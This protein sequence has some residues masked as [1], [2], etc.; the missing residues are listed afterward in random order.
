MDTDAR[1]TG[2]SIKN[3]SFGE[4]ALALANDYESIYVIDSENDS[5]VEYIAE[6]DNKELV[7]R[8]SG[9]DFYADVQV[10]CPAMVH[11]EDQA[12]FLSVFKKENVTEVLGSGRSFSI[13][14]R[15]IIDGRPYYYFLKTIKGTGDK[16]FIGVQ[17]VD[18]QRRH[19]LEM[20]KENLTYQ[21]IAGS[22]ASRYEVI[23]Y[24]NVWTNEFIMYS[25]SD[26]YSKL[27]RAIEG[28]DFFQTASQDIKEF[29]YHEDI[30]YVLAEL[31][32]DNLMRHLDDSG[33][34]SLKYRQIGTSEPQYMN[35]IIVHPKDDESHIVIGVMNIDA[36]ERRE[37]SMLE[38]SE[39]FGAVS[40][41][42]ASRYEVIY[43]VN[44]HTNEYYEYSSC[45]KYSKLEV[46]NI[47]K[48]FFKDTQENLKHEIYEEDYPMMAE[49][50]DKEKLL[51]KLKGAG[52]IFLNYRLML[53]GRPQYVSL[54]IISTKDDQDHIIVG[55]ENI[56]AA[57]RKE[58]EFEAAIGSA[59]DM[60]NKDALTG[61]K[62]KHAY[63]SMEAQLDSQMADEEEL[64]FAIA[65]CDINGL[66]QVNDEQGHSAGDKFIK[67]A[68]SII[69]KAFAHSP[70]FR[71]GGDEFVAVMRGSDYENRFEIVKK[72]AEI[73]N[74]NKREGLVTIAY[75]ISEYDPDRDNTVQDVFERADNLMY[76]NKRRIKGLDVSEVA[77][78]PYL[79]FYE[80]HEHLVTV[81][82]ESDH[83]DNEQIRDILAE[84]C[85]MFR[86]ARGEVMI[87]KNPQDEKNGVGDAI[88]CYDN[89]MMCRETIRLRF[90]TSLMS[91]AVC[92]VY[93][94][95]DEPPLTDEERGKVELIMRT[96]LS[97][98][99]SNI[100]NNIAEEL[101][102]Y[103]ESG[104]PNLRSWNKY[105]I[106]ALNTLEIRGKTSFRYNIRHFSIINQEF[107]RENGDA[108]M[109]THFENLRDIIGEGGF[110]ARLGGDNYIGMCPP[111]KL[112]EVVSYLDEA[113]VRVNDESE[114]QI[115]CK[116]GLFT[117]APDYSNRF[118]GD[119]MAKIISAYRAAQVSPSMRIVFYDDSI[120]ERKE[121]SMKVQQDFV[122]AIE[123]GEFVPFY[124][125]QVN[126]ITGEIIGAEAL[127]RWFRGGYMI[128]PMEFIPIL[129]QTDD[130]C[131]LDFHMLECVCRDMRRWM[132]EGR[133]MIAISVNFSRKHVLNSNLPRA[134]ADVLDRYGVPHEFIEIELTETT[135][136][137][138]FNEIKRI[139]AGFHELGIR[140]SVDD[141]GVGYTSLNLIKDIKWDVLK[142]DR[143]FLPDENDEETGF[144]KIMYSSVVT[145]ASK[146]GLTVVSEGVETTGQMDVMRDVG[147][148]IAQGFYFD[149]PLPVET[150]EERL[151]EGRYEVPD[152]R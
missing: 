131:K 102:Y 40:T 76:E 15:L 106:H 141:F 6:G 89:G 66:K 30:H 2:S 48:D 1:V 33:T 23:Y 117:F 5:Y 44:I 151:K 103:D 36:Q 99:S 146:L 91:S 26:E 20:E 11:P 101:A 114:V 42:L 25:A 55:V 111:D 79:K 64:E 28:K 128:P 129:E 112:D 18:E 63:V 59:I 70:V 29:I 16:V 150:F 3:I 52:K 137:Y 145:M 68:C 14:Y 125:P 110:L 139:A 140:I 9:D 113:A 143:S 81:M 43:W 92:T 120:M 78:D 115:T 142:I 107:G 24:V 4:I 149:R 80:L 86:L 148:D 87:Y 56:D 94:T 84:L 7:V 54:V 71:I 105:M 57:K 82:T 38:E 119:L 47:G 32:K 90:V 50:M 85:I 37:Q 74:T 65:V 122:E 147:C 49:A 27:G 95:P 88:C 104:Y 41:A 67:D 98:V 39:M 127:C 19:E 130:I 75:G 8:S 109:K 61:V 35:M 152:V 132:D 123:K 124:Q 134:I 100:L 73:Q 31:N 22:L 60:A 72:F 121:K 135:S 69:C 97:F 118:P 138:E 77:D 93:M 136:D 45:D 126:I 96:V 83:V 133:D 51:E 53:D 144:R 13:N 116:A 62:N 108:I 46:G 21:H 12:D 10:N 58:I 17:N 34:I